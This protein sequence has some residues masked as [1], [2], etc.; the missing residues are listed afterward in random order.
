[1]KKLTA[2]LLAAVSIISI[3]LLANNNASIPEGWFPTGNKPT[4]YEMGVDK[5]I[6]QSGK[7]SAFIK[8]KNPGAND[9][10]TLMQTISAENYLDK[11]LRLSGF[12]KTKE[13]KWF[14]RY[15]DAN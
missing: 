9:F 11:R 13:C 1:M 6:Y 14:E 4:E 2:L 12:I 10:G 7:S 8:S 15:V 3:Y 5:S